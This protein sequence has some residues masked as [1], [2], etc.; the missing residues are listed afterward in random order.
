MDLIV[1]GNLHR[2]PSSVTI[3]VLLRDLDVPVEGVA[4]AVNRLVVP[5]SAHESTTLSPKDSVEIIQAVGGG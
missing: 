3:A 1:N 5:R 2:A 4:V